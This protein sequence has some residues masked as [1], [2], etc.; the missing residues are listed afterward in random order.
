[1]WWTVPLSSYILT[2]AIFAPSL[3]II[4]CPFCWVGLTCDLHPVNSMAESILPLSWRQ[5]TVTDPYWTAWR[6]F[7][8]SLCGHRSAMGGGR[9]GW[10]GWPD[11]QDRGAFQS[12][13]PMHPRQGT[14]LNKKS[15]KTIQKLAYMRFAF[16]LC[17][18]DEWLWCLYAFYNN[19]YPWKHCNAAQQ[20]FFSTWLLVQSGWSTWS[21]TDW[22]GCGGERVS[23]RCHCF[24]NK[25]NLLQKSDTAARLPQLQRWSRNSRA[26]HSLAGTPNLMQGM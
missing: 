15:F 14:M 13:S 12:M 20:N 1:M 18:Q 7:F 23:D 24:G 10:G 9:G 22:W 21:Q 16:I 26:Q 8:Y 4:P 19:L 2:Q 6:T 25:K 11:L 17:I 5:C 3:D